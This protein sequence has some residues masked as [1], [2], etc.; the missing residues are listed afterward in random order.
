[1]LCSTCRYVSAVAASLSPTSPSVV[2]SPDN[3]P[4]ASPE[5][6]SCVAAKLR[7]TASSP[8]QAP[9]AASARSSVPA[10]SLAWP[11][12]PRSSRAPVS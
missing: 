11:A 6:F 12:N 7:P 2:E 10:I 9:N 4:A 8:Q 3:A 1:M 5:G